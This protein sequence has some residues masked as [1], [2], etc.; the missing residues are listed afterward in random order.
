M[1]KVD[2]FKEDG[3]TSRLKIKSC[4]KVMTWPIVASKPPSTFPGVAKSIGI[5][6]LRRPRDSK[7]LLIY[8]DAV[9]RF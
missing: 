7:R 6:F 4:T 1:K 3:H 2:E 9:L 5:P 8:A